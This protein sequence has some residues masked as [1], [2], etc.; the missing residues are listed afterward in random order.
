MWRRRESFRPTR[1]V[2][3]EGASSP[4]S[5]DY[6][7]TLA[8]ILL[9]WR[10]HPTDFVLQ[11][12][13]AEPDPWQCDVMDAVAEED[14]VA[15]RACHGVGK[16]ALLAWIIQWF[17]VT[18]PYSRVPSTAPT[19]N[20]QV[21]DVL[22]AEIRYW[23][24][25]GKQVSPW[26][27]NDFHISTTRL[28]HREHWKTWFAL[29]VASSTP[30]NAEGFHSQ[31]L[32]AVIDEA[33]AVRKPFW[34]SVAGMRT[35]QEAKLVVA[36]TPGGPLG[37][38]FKV[39]TEYRE[40]WK[41]TFVIHPIQLRETLKRHEAPPYSKFGTKYSSRVRD[42]FL[43]NSRLEWGVN[44]PAYIA[45]CIGD[46]PSTAD[47]VLIPYHWVVESFE[48][49]TGGG[50]GRVVA[51]DVARYGRD[52][53]VVLGG[54][55]GNIVRGKTIARTIEET[56]APE[57]RDLDSGVSEAKRFA[58]S[59][60]VTADACQALRAEIGA[61]IIVID[62]TGVGGAVS[63]IL[64]SRGERVLPIHFGTRATDVPRDAEDA[65]SRQRRHV[66]DSKFVDLKAQM[67][68]LLRGGFEDGIIALANLR[69][70][71]C[72]RRSETCQHLTSPLMKQLTSE[73][74]EMDV[75]GRLR[76]IDP[77]EQDEVASMIGAEEGRRSP[78]HLHS[79]MLYW[80]VAS[81]QAHV[82]PRVIVPQVPVGVARIGERHGG[83]QIAQGQASRARAG[84]VGGQGAYVRRW[85]R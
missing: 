49:D 42:Q 10:H 23:W 12:L 77:D 65:K 29:G 46:F 58:R 64:R 76:L 9:H 18:R 68:F 43:E 39:F 48:R 20:R 14:N 38:F 31:H 85:Y 81:G 17:T 44:S 84:I 66:L 3:R 75:K 74:Y 8:E 72:L 61:D 4:E 32:L 54:E 83:T 52:R 34:E 25:K 35:T 50:G 60:V 27:F 37:E 15:V 21:K 80:W 51:C 26:L 40:T 11:A 45:R 28:Q 69:C 78:D 70:D 53:T 41:S 67:G 55:G 7:N 1:I 57:G 79:L 2:E 30:F 36:S 73:K 13:G 16:T 33:K 24:D 47:D 5:L 71:D 56:T 6:T 62:D 22:W 19:Y 63:D 59:T 82:T